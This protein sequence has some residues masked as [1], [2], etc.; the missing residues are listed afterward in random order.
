MYYE[1]NSNLFDYIKIISVSVV[2]SF[3]NKA[4]ERVLVNE[5]EIA[6]IIIKREKSAKDM[7]KRYPEKI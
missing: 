4:E 7:N 5:Q 3:L 6:R 1:T 2:R